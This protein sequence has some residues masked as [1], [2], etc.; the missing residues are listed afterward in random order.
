MVGV[1]GKRCQRGGRPFLH[2]DFDVD[3][4]PACFGFNM[5]ILAC[6]NSLRVCDYLGQDVNQSD[7]IELLLEEGTG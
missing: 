1:G 2:R 3:V 6:N 5:R 7:Y 4:C